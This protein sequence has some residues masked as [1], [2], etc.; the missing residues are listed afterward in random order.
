MYLI[1]I[2]AWRLQKL[3]SANWTQHSKNLF[4]AESS[5]DIPMCRKIQMIWNIIDSVTCKMKCKRKLL[6][7]KMNISLSKLLLDAF[8]D[9]KNNLKRQKESKNGCKPAS[10]HRVPRTIY[11]R[12]VF[13]PMVTKSQG[14]IFDIIWVMK[15]F[16]MWR[17]KSK[18]WSY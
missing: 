17:I 6:M 15:F 9:P 10:F 11:R 2:F 1:Q 7:H 5:K 4:A 3:E 14:Y 18:M 16:E 13:Q 12:H 8:F